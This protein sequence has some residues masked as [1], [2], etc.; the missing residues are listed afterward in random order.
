MSK[1]RVINFAG[2]P[3]GT[4]KAMQEGRQAYIKK[5]LSESK[6]YALAQQIKIV[7]SCDRS[8]E[9]LF[10]D[11]SVVEDQ[12]DGLLGHVF[13]LNGNARTMMEK[14][15]QQAILHTEQVIG[16]VARIL[17][18]PKNP[19]QQQKQSYLDNLQETLKLAEELSLHENTWTIRKIGRLLMGIA[20]AAA[21]TA[22]VSYFLVSSAPIAMTVAVCSALLGGLGLY[23]QKFS[24]AASLKETLSDVVHNV[25]PFPADKRAGLYSSNVGGY[26]PYDSGSD[27]DNHQNGGGLLEGKFDRYF[28]MST[29]GNIRNYLSS[30]LPYS[31][32]G[33]EFKRNRYTMSP[34]EQ[35]IEKIKIG[36][37]QRLASGDNELELHDQLSSDSSVAKLVAS[38]GIEII[39]VENG[40]VFASVEELMA[41]GGLDPL[42]AD[43]PVE[44]LK[45]A[46][47]TLVAK[48]EAQYT[49][50]M[51]H[52]TNTA[53][54]VY[55][56]FADSRRQSDSYTEIAMDEDNLLVRERFQY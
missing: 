33:S 17:N 20:A 55:S 19:T 53:K 42:G 31:N 6:D 36:L 54:A 15:Q 11:K 2:V 5:H 39:P 7:K 32:S 3:Y 13:H 30:Q 24:K 4:P 21:I 29:V 25:K 10:I 22:I 40:V 47:Q 27:D 35:L 51:T 44:A 38:S 12:L 41:D 23:L 16:R 34:S 45:S 26:E 56:F 8:K 18:R 1:Y 9:R 52:I 14:E 48:I 49:S 28:N 50:P 46:Y 37:E 43:N